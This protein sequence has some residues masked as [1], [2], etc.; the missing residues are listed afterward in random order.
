MNYP[1]QRPAIP[2]M[3]F[4]VWQ[5]CNMRC[6]YCFAEFADATQRLRNDKRK[7][8]E[9]AL[10]IVRAAADAGIDKITFVGGEPLLCPWLTE[11][12][13]F[14]TELGMVT[15]VVSNGSRMDGAWITRHA[16]W[17]RWAGVSI[18]SLNPSVNRQIGRNV[19]SSFVPNAKF[20]SELL[21]ALSANG[22]RTKVNTVVSAL[23]WQEDFADFLLYARPERWKVLQ[24]LHVHGEND[25]AFPDLACTTKQFDY[26]VERHLALASK[27]MIAAEDNEAMT[28]SYLMVDPLGRFFS[29]IGGRHSYSA[30]I[31]EV[32]WN[33]ALSTIQASEQKFITRGGHYN[34][35]GPT[36]E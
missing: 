23:N 25:E 28:G 5:P 4:H 36:G 3:N 11:L 1:I 34:W 26:F 32:G 20:Y 22:V 17:L 8:R 16:H 12:L 14:S 6:R 19:G 33:E 35:R 9:R 2:A 30:P 29:N 18:D 31:W 24:A 10:A 15:M 13:K 7:L 21:L 27:M